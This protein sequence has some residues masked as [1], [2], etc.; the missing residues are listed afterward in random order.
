[1]A[2]APNTLPRVPTPPGG[3]TDK[4]LR[5]DRTA[6]VVVLA[7]LIGLMALL[8]W[9]ASFGTVPQNNI[10]DFWPMMP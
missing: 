7:V 2:T 5:H 4:Q 3:R 10:H 9:L 8:I 6:A 1:M